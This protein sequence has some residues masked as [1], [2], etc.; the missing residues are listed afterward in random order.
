MQLVRTAGV[1]CLFFAL[2]AIADPTAALPPPAAL[3][4]GRDRPIETPS[5]EAIL[6]SASEVAGRW[7]IVEETPADLTTDPDLAGWGVR[8]QRARHYTRN[9]VDGAQVCTVEVWIF[10]TESSAR[11]AAERFEYPQ[12][13][14]ERSGPVLVLYHAVTLSE[15]GALRRIFGDCQHLGEATLARAR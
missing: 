15:R 12:W 10:E 13:K 5:P 1:V 3:E 6:P 2:P 11:W 4:A 8:A 7:S 14:I 9:S